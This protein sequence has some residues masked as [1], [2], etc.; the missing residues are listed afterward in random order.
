ME[1]TLLVDRFNHKEDIKELKNLWIEDILI[2]L[3]LD[4]EE[5]KKLSPDN[6]IEMLDEKKIELIER[7]SNGEL[8]VYLKGDLIGKWAGPEFTLKK[9]KRTK[10]FYYEVSIQYWSIL[11]DDVS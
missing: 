7:H 9:D 11:N 3:G 4:L 1:I 6:F 5:V 2:Y 8:N 10:E